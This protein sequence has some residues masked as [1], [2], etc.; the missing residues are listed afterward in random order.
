M[1]KLSVLVLL[2]IMVLGNMSISAF[3]EENGKAGSTTVTANVPKPDVEYEIVIPSAVIMNEAGVK[4]IGQ[5]KINT[6]EGKLK[7]ATKN[8]V[9]SYT[10][11]CTD[12]K[13]SNDENKTMEATYYA[14]YTDATINTVLGPDP[15]IVYKDSALV[16]P[17]TTLY[18]GVTEDAWITAGMNAPGT[19]NATV[20]FDFEVGDIM[21]VG[22]VLAT[23]NG[24]FP[25][26][27]EFAWHSTN[28]DFITYWSDSTNTL[29]FYS[30]SESE[31]PMASLDLALP[32]I[33]V[34]DSYKF[35]DENSKISFDFKMT[36]GVLTSIV[37]VFSDDN[38]ITYTAQE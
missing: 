26:D 12:F 18:V 31:T 30:N 28:T 32:L 29:G 2:L 23:L 14:A 33:P 24:I 17:L 4:E 20:T 15:I 37:V 5:A 10:A 19:Y 13:L 38:S 36:E 11:S 9:I 6:A 7:Y 25:T 34:G 22:E 8:T 35:Y 3:A 21:T 1:K 27:D 16:D